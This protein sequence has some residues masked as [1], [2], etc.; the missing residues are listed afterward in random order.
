MLLF[1]NLRILLDFV[2]IVSSKR[3]FKSYIFF[4]L[5]KE[6]IKNLTAFGEFSS[7]FQLTSDSSLISFGEFLVAHFSIFK[8]IQ[9]Y[10]NQ[11]INKKFKQLYKLGVLNK[12]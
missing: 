3:S 6:N 7:S 9:N 8:I 4:L 12:L 10:T 2:L 5:H 1:E 11:I